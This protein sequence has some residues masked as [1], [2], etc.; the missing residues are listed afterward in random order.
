MDKGLM[1]GRCESVICYCPC[2]S[3]KGHVDGNCRC[4]KEMMNDYLA[5]RKLA[6]SY[7]CRGYL[8]MSASVPKSIFLFS[9]DPVI[10]VAVIARLY[11]GFERNDAS[12]S[13]L[14]HC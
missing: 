1:N 13:I 4:W 2:E 7:V 10:P 8:S 11:L 12:D 9:P 14:L 5:I 6:D 3:M